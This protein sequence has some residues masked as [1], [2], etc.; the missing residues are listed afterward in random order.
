MSK[1][2][3]ETKET[4]TSKKEK[5]VVMIPLEAFGFERR[6]YAVGERYVMA[7]KEL[8]TALKGKYKTQEVKES[9]KAVEKETEAKKKAI[10]VLGK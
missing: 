6:A 10:P 8:P 3:T 9:K 7:Q 2:N 1:D 4:K 5:Q